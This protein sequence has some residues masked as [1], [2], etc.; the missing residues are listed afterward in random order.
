MASINLTPMVP[1]LLALFAVVFLAAPRE[2]PVAS[3]D[4]PPGDCF[5]PCETPPRIFVSFARD[6]RVFIDGDIV[7]F[8]EAPRVVVARA[9]ARP[10][11]P[12]M[13][14]ADAE[15]PYAAVFGIFRSMDR[16]GLRPPSL[17]SEELS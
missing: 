13:I 9:H 8:A 16:A 17:I 12:V 1:V 6:G 4:Q 11:D 5:G 2:A 15:V 3:L 7:S 14:R 10:G